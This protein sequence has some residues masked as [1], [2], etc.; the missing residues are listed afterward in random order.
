MPSNTTRYKPYTIRGEPNASM[1]EQI[2][3]MFGLLFQ[4]LELNETSKLL[5]STLAD[6]NTGSPSEGAVIVGSDDTPSKWE[7]STTPLFIDTTN[8]R[9][10][11]KSTAPSTTL[12]VAR[13]DAGTEPT[14]TASDVAILENTSGSNS[15]L[16]LFTSNAAIG[17]IGFSDPDARSIGTFNYRHSNNSMDWATNS[18]AKM[19]LNTSGQLGLGDSIAVADIPVEPRLH[20][21]KGNAGTD[22][23]WTTADVGL[24]ENVSGTD[25]IINIFTGTADTGGIGFSD[26]VRN[27][28]SI[29]YNHSTDALAFAT[30]ATSRFTIT[31]A[32]LFNFATDS[33]VGVIDT[34][35]SHYMRLDCGSDLTADR[36]LSFV[37]GDAARTLTFAGD[38]TISGTNSGDVTLAGT[39]DYITISA[40]V[41]TRGLID[42]ATDVTGVLPIANGGTATSS[43]T[44]TYTPTR[45]AETNL[46]ANVT[47]TEAQYLRVG[48]TVTISGRFTADPTLTAT[49][50]SFELSLPVTSNI[51]AVEDVAGVAFCG[52]I[53]GM[54][55]AINGSVANDTAVVQWV[56]SDVTSQTWSYILTYQII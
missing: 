25:G 49:A 46:D 20:V 10:G 41:I 18:T 30:A 4:D 29:T 16:N 13:G 32:G 7:S 33:G 48:N 54:G 26:T 47:M 8:L 56:A 44:Q 35:A 3:E 42:L 9:V 40:Q 38:A 36:T 45:S 12:H 1:M 11:I 52:N 2:D 14:W 50:T 34:N 21:R 51:G 27:R 43:T 5:A 55:A 22:P 37:P 39:P 15:V 28:G 19:V 31:S 17:G 24:F 23:T 6:V 53:S